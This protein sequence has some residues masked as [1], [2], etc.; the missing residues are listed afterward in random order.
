MFL[1]VL[2][3]HQN[4]P[5]LSCCIQS[6]PT[7]STGDCY[8]MHNETLGQGW[9]NFFYRGPHWK[10]YCCRRAAYIFCLLKLQLQHTKIWINDNNYVF[11]Q[12]NLHTIWPQN[13]IKINETNVTVVID[14]GAIKTDLISVD[15]NQ[16]LGIKLQKSCEHVRAYGLHNILW[17]AACSPRAIVYPPLL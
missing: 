8:V 1:H 12:L 16:I 13:S 2:C 3:N 10:F 15:L 4:S 9:A 7:N 6:C 5:Q 14:P 11:C 17:Q